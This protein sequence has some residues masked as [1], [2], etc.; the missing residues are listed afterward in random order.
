MKDF[1]FP[2][3][4]DW[5]LLIEGELFFDSFDAESVSNIGVDLH[6]GDLFAIPSASVIEL[7]EPT[8][9][10]FV[11]GE[12]TLPAHGF[13]L[14]YSKEELTLPPNFMARIEPVSTNLRVGLQVS[15]GI[16][17]A[18]F[19]GNLT[20]GLSNLTEQFIKLKSGKRICRLIIERCNETTIPYEGKYQNSEKIVGAKK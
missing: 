1:N 2:T 19:K 15:T 11:D 17:D 4:T 16:V 18:G 10:K 9:Y 6:L 14:G 5:Q 8:S 3:L 7:G 20:L 13:C 12:Y